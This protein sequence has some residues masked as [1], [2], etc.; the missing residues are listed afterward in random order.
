MKRIAGF[1]LT[2]A[3]LLASLCGCTLFPLSIQG[4]LQHF[5]DDINLGQ[6]DLRADAYENFHPDIALYAAIQGYHSGSDYYWDIYFPQTDPASVYTIS[7]IVDT[8]PL[9]VTATISA[10]DVPSFGTRDAK[11]VMAEDENS[12]WLIK[13]LWLDQSGTLTQIIW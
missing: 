13:E 3:A 6:Y 10:A 7:D 11:F 9:N 2:S 1:I 5:I 8:D 12:N 4:R